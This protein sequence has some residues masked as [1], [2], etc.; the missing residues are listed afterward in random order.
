[1][2]AMAKRVMD[3]EYIVSP[4]ERHGNMPPVPTK[5]VFE[6]FGDVVVFVNGVVVNHE[7]DIEVA[8][9]V[10]VDEFEERQPLL[11]TVPRST[12]GEDLPC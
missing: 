4:R 7:V 8:R 2:A 6:P 11:M 1:M 3:L 9:D 12:V 5:R 10:T